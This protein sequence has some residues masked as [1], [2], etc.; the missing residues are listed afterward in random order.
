MTTLPPPP[1]PYAS[2]LLDVGDGHQIYWEEAGNPDGKPAL[3]LHGGPGSGSTP[4][5]RRWFGHAD[6]YRAIIIDQRNCGRS[7]PSAADPTTD[8]STNTT[9]DLIAD[10]ELLRIEK[11]IDRWQVFG[12]SW[13]VTLA[14]VYAETYPQRVSELVLAAVTMTRA[15]DVHWLYHEVGRYF[16]EQWRRYRD[17]VPEAERDGDL[18]A[19][20][21]RLLNVSGNAEVMSAAAQNWVDWEDAVNSMDA[22]W[23]PAVRYQ[24]P[25]FRMTFARMCAHYFSHAAWLE[26]Q[27]IL[28]D[29]HRLAGIPGVMV[30]GKHDLGGPSDVP[31]LLQQEWPEAELHLV[32]SGHGGNAMGAP[33]SDFVGR[34]ANR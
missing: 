1:D 30:H 4:G 28:R 20:Y 34:Y 5:A 19:A 9:Q 7:L 24:D 21:N 29:A 14:L 11:G 13:G 18:V 32:D 25:V 16:P 22:N 27:Q 17:G 3:Y 31:W 10:L 26:D 6:K 23:T 12:G 8:L 2:G 15:S 33:L